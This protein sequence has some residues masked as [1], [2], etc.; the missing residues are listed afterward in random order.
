MKNSLRLT[1][2]ALLMAAP[3]LSA[4]THYVSW[5]S[6][7]PTPPYTNWATAAT[8]IQQAI[9]PWAAVA[10]D[11]V[12]V[13][14]GVYA[15][16]VYVTARLALRSVNGPQFTVID[17]NFTDRC[18]VLRRD[19]ASLT[20]FTLTRGVGTVYGSGYGGGVY[21]DYLNGFLTNCTLAGNRAGFPYGVGGGAYGCTLY[22][23]TLTGNSAPWPGGA[24]SS[25]LYNCTLTG[26]SSGED[27][28]AGQGCTLYNCIVY[29]NSA[30]YS[31]NYAP[32]CT[33]NYCCT[34]PLPDSGV[35]NI[36]SDPLFVGYA[37]GNLHLQS[38]SPCIDAGNNNFVTTDTDLD[39]NPRIVSGTVDIGAYEYQGTPPIIQTPPLTQ[40]AEAGSAVDFRVKGVGRLPL[41]CFWYF[42]DTNLISWSTN[43]A[44]LLTNLQFS[45]AG[46]YEVVVTNLLGAVTSPPALLSVIAPVERRMVPGL[47]LAGQP[48]TSL[49]LD[50]TAALGPAPVWTTFD[51]VLLTAAS[52]WYFDVSSPLPPQGFYRSWQSSAGMPSAQ[53]LRFVPALTLTGSVG[54]SVR[55]DAISQFGP[56][57]A[58]VT[59][60][61]VTLTNTSQLYFDTSAWGQPQR[62][63]RL[64]PVP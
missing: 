35:G 20:G 15:G 52:Q 37:N 43:G 17:G 62:L 19:G 30:R 46:A 51:H 10:G 60:D 48:G 33:L 49:N 2:I 25:T 58:W 57:D 41:F 36:S 31:A 12:L 38:S 8:S 45:Q 16:P 1:T 61:T 34:T 40:T 47:I 55:V 13:A 56:I 42:G 22:N 9:A 11:V 5:G 26:N 32:G 44:L 63:Y 6:T 64:V 39:G 4:A 23:C 28:G 53:N 29:N 21:C 3:K 18:V 27:G 50:F 59:L 7:N 54:G 14:N 24:H